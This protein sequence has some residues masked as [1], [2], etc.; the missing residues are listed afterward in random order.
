[1][2]SWT[3]HHPLLAFYVL[4]YLVS[5]AIELPLAAAR[6]GW[7]PL[8]PPYAM[9]YL[10]S[11]GPM[12]AALVVTGVTGGS[13]G[14]RDLGRRLSVRR[15]ALT[16]ALLAGLVPLALFGLA[17]IVEHIS[18][19]TWPNIALLGD[20]DFL[21]PLGIAGAV[22]FWLLT[23]GLGEKVGW[24][25]FAQPRLQVRHGT[26]K[27]ALLA[28]VPWALWHLPI[29]LYKDTCLAMGLTAGLPM[30]LVSLAATSIVFGWLVDIARGNLWPAILFHGIFDLLSASNAAEP[31]RAFSLTDTVTLMPSDRLLALPVIKR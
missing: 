18:L 28:S 23:F 8:Q 5:W 29:F 20:V 17:A 27:A 16:V 7:L 1:M 2:T 15:R 9:H 24:R 11:F 26:T 10:A 3:R 14:L 19:G 12:V 13:S 21:P 30:L 6:Q 4:A 31:T 25:G 22:V